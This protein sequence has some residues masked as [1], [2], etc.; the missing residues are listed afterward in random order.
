ME[1]DRS[2]MGNTT[3]MKMVLKVSEGVQA[4]AVIGFDGDVVLGCG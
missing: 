4:C 3:G 2:R 1:S